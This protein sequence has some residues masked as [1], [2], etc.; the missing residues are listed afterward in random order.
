MSVVVV[1]SASSSVGR[2]GSLLAL[3]GSVD[4]ALNLLVLVVVVADMADVFPE[5]YPTDAG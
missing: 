5:A 3:G 4:A 1:V 2:S